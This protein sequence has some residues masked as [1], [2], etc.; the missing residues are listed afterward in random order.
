MRNN[1]E[2][3]YKMSAYVDFK[4]EKARFLKIINK[5][6]GPK[7]IYGKFRSK[8]YQNQNFKNSVRE[9]SIYPNG[10]IKSFPDNDCFLFDFKIKYVENR[11][12]KVYET[13]F[14]DCLQKLMF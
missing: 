12:E 2:Y 4:S 14:N 13:Q 8:E 7:V 9:G 3:Q 11:T 10:I 6:L 1:G 5:M